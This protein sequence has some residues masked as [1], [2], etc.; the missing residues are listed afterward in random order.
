MNFYWVH[1]LALAELVTND[2]VASMDSKM[3]SILR[4]NS[5]D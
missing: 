1:F 2:F 5:R 3:L 4:S